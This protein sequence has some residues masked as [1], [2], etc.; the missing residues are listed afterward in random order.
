[1]SIRTI[2]LIGDPVLEHKC[3][4]VTD[5]DDHLKDLLTDLRDTMYAAPG[6]GL[7]ANQIG[8]SRHVAVVDTTV[9]EQEG[10]FIVLVNPRI[11][12]EEGQQEEEEG[13]LSVPDVTEKV[14]RPM[15][16]TV[17]AQDADGNL[18][19]LQGEGLLARAFCHEI[20]H[21]NG[22]FF[23]DRLK[24]LKKALAYR[25]ARKIQKAG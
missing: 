19:V 22:G 10:T 3:A 8:V 9:G 21:L 4:P 23:L 17:E 11:V 2:R 13:C 6:V 5:F 18:Q 16:V 24:G 12:A 14:V 25:K 1:M 15:K 20:D 7:A